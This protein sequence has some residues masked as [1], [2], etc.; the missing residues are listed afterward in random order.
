MPDYIGTFKDGYVFV[1]FSRNTPQISS[2]MSSDS[3]EP[4]L[5]LFDEEYFCLEKGTVEHDVASILK[6]MLLSGTDVTNNSAAH[7]K[8]TN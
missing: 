2:S 1:L 8:P 5:A 6:D 3:K 4:W 7:T